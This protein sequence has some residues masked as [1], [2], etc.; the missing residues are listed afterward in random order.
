MPTY[1]ILE[2]ILGSFN[3]ADQRFGETA[4]TQCTCNALFA[5]F[6]SHIRR[7]SIWKTADLDK[8]LIEGDALYKNLNTRNILNVDEMPR[9]IEL[10][11]FI[12]G[13]NYQDLKDCEANLRND[14]PFLRS[15]FL[16]RNSF[17]VLMII[18][19]VTISIFKCESNNVIYL[20]DSHSRNARGLLIPDGTSCL[21][22]FWSVR[23][24]EKYIQVFY[25]EL[26]GKESEFFQLQFISF[27]EVP[28]ALRT[29]MQVNFRNFSRKYN[30]NK[31]N[32]RNSRN[33]HL[34]EI[35][36][37]NYYTSNK[38]IIKEKRTCILLQLKVVV[39]LKSLQ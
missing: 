17:H 29:S 13:V 22:S 6:W 39:T 3:Q 36:K 23:E 32:L 1:N 16:D 37:S 31:N 21:L 33:V 7:V 28:V 10:N 25:L 20:F 18:S 24:L 9:F 2:A 38:E 27:N 8:I 12:I 19:G 5:A 30:Y 14:D 4:G 35:E 11:N 26:R 15:Q 34:L